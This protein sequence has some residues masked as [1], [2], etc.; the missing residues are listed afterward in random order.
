MYAFGGRVT[1][2]EKDCWPFISSSRFPYVF[3]EADN[4]QD[5]YE[6]VTTYVAMFERYAQMIE[7]SATAKTFPVII[8]DE[9]EPES[10]F[11]Y[12][13]TV[14][15]RAEICIATSVIAVT[16]FLMNNQGSTTAQQLLSLPPM[17]N[18]VTLA[19]GAFSVSLCN[20]QRCEPDAD[21]HLQRCE[22]RTGHAASSD[23]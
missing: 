18:A 4:Y 14:S 21:N 10:V 5:Y 16:M 11:N 15:S 6:K 3:G 19:G 9:G 23:N 22:H 1:T 12:I 8:E 2:F 20:Q 7:P 17:T 13:D